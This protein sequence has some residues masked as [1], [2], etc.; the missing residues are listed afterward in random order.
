[1]KCNHHLVNKCFARSSKATK[2]SSLDP[3][4][5]SKTLT[6]ELSMVDSSGPIAAMKP[7]DCNVQAVWAA[8][9]P[10][11]N[12]PSPSMAELVLVLLAS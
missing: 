11:S 8:A 4:L 6:T 2:R 12:Q 7:T 1:M 10:S 5:L 3:Q 9:L